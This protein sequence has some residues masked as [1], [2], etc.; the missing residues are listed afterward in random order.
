MNQLQRD[1][2]NGFIYKNLNETKKYLG[3]IKYQ[4]ATL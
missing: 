2:W 1:L 4:R 3:Q